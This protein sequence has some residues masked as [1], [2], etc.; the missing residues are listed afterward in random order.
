MSTKSLKTLRDEAEAAL[1]SGVSSIDDLKTSV[2][3]LV[4]LQR[5]IHATEKDLY[6]TKSIATAL[7]KATCAYAHENAQALFKETLQV[8]PIGVERGSLDIDG[9][10]Y[11]YSRGFDGYQRTATGYT[12]SQDF[13]ATLPPEWT[14]Y[15]LELNIKSVTNDKLPPETLAEHG[16]MRKTKLSWSK[17]KR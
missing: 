15:T 13:L 8:S 12:L 3:T 2:P 10:T 6:A 7:L 5:A 16:L 9:T 1:Q 17:N 14:K 11:H 4:A